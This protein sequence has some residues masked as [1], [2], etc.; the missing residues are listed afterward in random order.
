[1]IFNP[2]EM[3]IVIERRFYKNYAEEDYLNH[4]Q[5]RFLAFLH[6]L[7]M[8]KPAIHNIRLRLKVKG[9]WSP[10]ASTASA[11]SAASSCCF[12]HAK[13]L[14]KSIDST[15][16]KDITLNDIELKDH[17]IKTTIHSGDTVS[18]MIACSDNPIPIDFMGLVK[19][20][21]GLSRAEERL[22]MVMC[23]GSSAIS[24]G[25]AKASTKSNLLLLSKAQIPNP[26][27]WMVTMWHFGR[28]S[29]NGYSGEM[30]EIPWNEELQLFRIHSK[31]YKKNKKIRIRK[32]TQEYPNKSLEEALMDKL[33]EDKIFS[34]EIL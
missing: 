20:T 4:K 5:N 11:S 27:S 18:V 14:I 6:N 25:D 2:W 10:V 19:L 15:E 12:Q 30:F 17:I 28:D 26:M 34:I 16:N 7:S 9:L 23:F 24:G 22:Q 32:E 29:L 31:Q 3:E 13:H 33:E 8:D 1:M 21:S